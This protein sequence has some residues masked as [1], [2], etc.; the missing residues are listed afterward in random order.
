MQIACDFP[1]KSGS[2]IYLSN[3]GIRLLQCVPENY[4]VFR[5][6]VIFVPENAIFGQASLGWVTGQQV[7]VFRVGRHH[8]TAGLCAESGEGMHVY[9]HGFTLFVPENHDSQ[10]RVLEIRIA[11]QKFQILSFM[12]N[13]NKHCLFDFSQEQPKRLCRN[14][15]KSLLDALRMHER[16]KQYRFTL[17]SALACV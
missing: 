4:A 7:C 14:L 15:Q 13:N 1:I 2:Q 16:K 6:L 17:G 9:C 3:V 8:G 12:K 10:Q 11:S 5:I